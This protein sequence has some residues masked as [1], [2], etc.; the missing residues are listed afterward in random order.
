[1]SISCGCDFYEGVRTVGKPKFMTCRTAKKCDE[2]GESIKLGDGLYRYNMYDWDDYQV[3]APHW[4]CESC[5]DLMASI[6][7][8]GFCFYLGDIKGQWKE[9]VLESTNP[10]T[11][12]LE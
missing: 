5:G 6:A 3:C 8:Q 4:M 10:I 11:G 12:K 1:M 7:A 9:Y 2:C